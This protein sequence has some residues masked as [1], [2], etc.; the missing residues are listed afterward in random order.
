MAENEPLISLGDPDSSPEHEYEEFPFPEET[1]EV[2][3][4][5]WKYGAFMRWVGTAFN[6]FREH[7]KA[8]GNIYICGWLII[9]LEIPMFMSAAPGIQ[10][11]ED[12]VCRKIYG[13]EFTHEMCQGKD[14]QT[15]IAGIRGVLA[16]LA[17][18]PSKLSGRCLITGEVLTC[19]SAGLLFAVPYGMLADKKG[20]KF[21]VGLT[22]GAGFFCYLWSFCVL[23]F[24]NTLPFGLIYT[25]PLILWIGGGGFVAGSII[26][27]IAAEVVPS[28]E[29]RLESPT[30]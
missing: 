26:T 30:P 28:E 2:H 13:H 11:I 14:V 15:R 27:A 23:Y 8:W 21:V 24:Y 19:Q 25:Y 4:P 9:G 3:L 12:A 29:A 22:V 5:A 20:R 7:L 16:V 17:A 10:L 1:D 6:G 18:I